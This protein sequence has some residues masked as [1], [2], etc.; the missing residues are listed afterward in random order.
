MHNSHQTLTLATTRTG[1]TGSPSQGV[2]PVIREINA[3]DL[4]QFGGWEANWTDSCALLT[5]MLNAPLPSHVGQYTQHAGVRALRVAARRLWITAGVGQAP[6][7]A[8][9][10]HSNSQIGVVTDL[11]HSRVLFRVAGEG[12][13]ALM[14]TLLPVD[15]DASACARYSVV[16]SHIHQ[17]PVLAAAFGEEERA[18]VGFDLYV[19]RTF[20]KSIHVWIV[21]RGAVQAS[22]E[23]WSEPSP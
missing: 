20:A 14:S 10:G 18:N 11:S 17:V 13:R 16:Q 9:R 6:M 22:S 7:A 23:A 3:F 19:P 2:R 4:L 15:F 1:T 5:D 8:L 21:D 12:V